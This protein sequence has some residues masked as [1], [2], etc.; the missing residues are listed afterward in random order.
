MRIA[1]AS[2]QESIASP[3]TGATREASLRAVIAD[4]VPCTNPNHN[5]VGAVHLL[6]YS[7][8]RGANL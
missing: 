5:H 4:A 8:E 2:S 7:Q 3:C 6:L 1:I